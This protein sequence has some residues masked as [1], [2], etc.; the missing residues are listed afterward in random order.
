MS[1]TIIRLMSSET[2][3]GEIVGRDSDALIIKHPVSLETVYNDG[4]RY[5]LMRDMLKDSLEIHMPINAINIMYTFP[6]APEVEDYYKGCL[7]TFE[8]AKI[9][10]RGMYVDMLKELVES[11]LEENMFD[12]KDGQILQPSSTTE[13]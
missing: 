13:N 11:T 4:S 6:A 12:I 9:A 2:I 5:V 10:H 3:I 7:P 1:T 8:K